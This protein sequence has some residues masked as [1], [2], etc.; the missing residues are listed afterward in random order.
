MD[1]Y[2]TDSGSDV[3]Y[4]DD[5]SGDYTITWSMPLRTPPVDDTDES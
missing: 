3:V 2:T 5:G 4:E 1:K